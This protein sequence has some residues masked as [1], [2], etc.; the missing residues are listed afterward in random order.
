MSANSQKRTLALPMKVEHWL[1]TILRKEPVKIGAKVVSHG[2][3]VTFQ[4]AEVAIPRDLLRR[5]PAPHRPAQSDAHFGMTDGIP[6]IHADGR[7]GASGMRPN[8]PFRP[9]TP[10]SCRSIR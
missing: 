3:Y 1:L 4:S 8:G 7:I 2:R 9:A 6:L 10:A 5:H